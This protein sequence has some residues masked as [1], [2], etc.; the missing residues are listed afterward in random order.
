MLLVLAVCHL[1]S[2]PALVARPAAVYGRENRLRVARDEEAA[3]EEEAQVQERHEQAE[4]EHRHQLLLQRARARYYGGAELA[5]SQETPAE[6]IER[7]PDS[8]TTGALEAVAD[9]RAPPASLPATSTAADDAEEAKRREAPRKRQRQ[10]R[11]PA[12]SEEQ[13]GRALTLAELAQQL[14]P[15]QAAAPEP[16]SH[17]A[18]A[19]PSPG[20]E[21]P[22]AP[23]DSVPRG[24][25]LA[26]R[27]PNPGQPPRPQHI[28]LF[29]EEEA[30]A[31]NA[32]KAEEARQERRRRGDP[33]TQTSDARFDQTFAFGNGVAGAAAPVPWYCKPAPPDAAAAEP[34]QH[35]AAQL[36]AW[37]GVPPP[38][39]KAEPAGAL[40][41][42][43]PPL[44]LQGVVPKSSAKGEGGS[45]SEDRGRR[46]G[47]GKRR[48][49]EKRGSKEGRKGGRGGKEA[50]A[51][52]A[53]AASAAAF[54]ALREER[55][56]R[57]AVER[58][59]EGQVQRQAA[60]RHGDAPDGRRYHTGFGFGRK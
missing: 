37:R 15:G 23:H 26:R 31:A 29:V 32:E 13:P 43:P 38:R 25:S 41:G 6:R 16:G 56:L 42:G 58:R 33:K 53:R 8:A 14:D 10:R 44:L 51:A 49:K 45:S 39:G 30:R 17:P 54:A 21:L 3:A 27:D 48:R 5:G 12:P 4:R 20:A 24:A 22:V 34:P 50:D 57:E 60:G 1:E 7:V 19:P 9:G 40:Q 36:D 55:L 28:N 18:A 47:H 2:S 52:A 11:P 35:H 46:S 59:R